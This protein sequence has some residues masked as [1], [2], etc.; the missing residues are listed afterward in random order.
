MQLLYRGVRS[1]LLA[2]LAVLFITV[3]SAPAHAASFNITTSPLPVLLATKPGVPVS[4]TLRVQNSGTE[5]TRF[6]VSLKKFRANG[7]TGK[8]LLQNRGPNDEYFDWVSFSETSFLAEP[9][10]WHQ[11]TM[12]IKPP[13]DAAFGYY[14]GVVFSGEAPKAN[15]GGT[16]NQ[17][18]GATAVLVLL[19]VQTPGEKK[20]L[21]IVSFSANKKLYE[22]LPADFTVKV[23]NSG[24]IHLSPS[25]TIFISKGKKTI[26]TLDVNP[27]GGNILPSSSR[28]FATSWKDGFPVFEP[29]HDQ[30][31]TVTNKNGQPE[32]TLHWDFSKANHLRMGH[33]T[34]NLVLTYDNGTRDVPLEA[35][36]SFW[37]VPWKL[38]PFILLGI[39]LIGIGLWTSGKNI[40]RRAQPK[41]FSK[42]D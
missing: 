14:Y 29:K 41:K 34:A 35:S 8:P 5:T 11:I 18:Q 12:T 27:A 9:G 37:V 4:T 36:V 30:S 38:L 28:D 22:Y 39:V 20:Q 1:V 25:G 16:T 3:N 6:N 7:A 15:P 23:K 33:Y 10:V 26:A 32:Q 19:D 42:N 40:W 21:N 13:A 17:L 31:G 2:S 24:D